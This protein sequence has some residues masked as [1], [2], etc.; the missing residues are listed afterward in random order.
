[1]VQVTKELF[2]AKW[3]AK[4]KMNY[5]EIWAKKEIRRMRTGRRRVCTITEVIETSTDVIPL[6]DD[7]TLRY[8]DQRSP[9]SLESEAGANLDHSRPPQKSVVFSQSPIGST[10]GDHRPEKENVK[11]PTLCPPSL[12]FCVSNEAPSPTVTPGRRRTL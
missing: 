6:D 12:N 11:R 9:S 10:P 3:R 2:E 7:D 1:M 4:I 5:D 8:H